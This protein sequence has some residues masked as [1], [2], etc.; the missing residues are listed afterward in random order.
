MIHFAETSQAP[1]SYL[2]LQHVERVV[3]PKLVP[4]NCLRYLKTALTMRA[5]E[6]NLEY[7]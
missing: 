3:T 2:I 4:R 5:W 6:L 7:M 1:P